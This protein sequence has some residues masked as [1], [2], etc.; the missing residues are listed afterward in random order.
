MFENLIGCTFSL[1]FMKVIHVQLA[2]EGG[3]VVVLEVLRQD[4]VSK[5][6]WTLNDE[7]LTVWLEPVYNTRCGSPIDNFIQFE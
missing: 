2:D 1:G 4:L 6:L 7:A 5:K 3:E